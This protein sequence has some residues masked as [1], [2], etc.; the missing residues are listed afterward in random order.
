[1]NINTLPNFPNHIHNQKGWKITWQMLTWIQDSLDE[2]YE[3]MIHGDLIYV[4]GDSRAVVALLQT[5]RTLIIK[6]LSVKCTQ[7]CLLKCINNCLMYLQAHD[8]LLGLHGCACLEIQL[9]AGL[10]IYGQGVLHKE[11]IFSRN[12]VQSYPICCKNCY[13]DGSWKTPVTVA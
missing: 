6:D 13:I 5:V 1:M 10:A 8:K 11:S 2:F 4:T 7:F 3:I 9:V 12:V